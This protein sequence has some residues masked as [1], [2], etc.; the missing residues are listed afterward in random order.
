[1]LADEKS[2]ELK[3]KKNVNEIQVD[4]NFGADG[5]K[6]K[7]TLAWTFVDYKADTVKKKEQDIKGS[8]G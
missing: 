2:K 3:S 1:M 5:R 4:D 8:Y 6:K 7:K